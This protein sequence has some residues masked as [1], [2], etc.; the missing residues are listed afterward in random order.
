M[1]AVHQR[2]RHLRPRR[3][4][5]S[6]RR[7]SC[8]RATRPAHALRPRR[9]EFVLDGAIG[10]LELD[11]TADHQD[12]RYF[13]IRG[14]EVD[15]ARRR[16]ISGC[17]F[18]G[19][20]NAFGNYFTKRGNV[21]HVTIE[22]VWVHGAP[23]VPGGTCAAIGL[24]SKQGGVRE[25]TT[26]NV[27]HI[28]IDDVRIDGGD[29]GILVMTELSVAGVPPSDQWPADVNQVCDDIL[30]SNV[31]FD[32]GKAPPF[33]TRRHHVGI[34]VNG[35][36]RGGT[37]TVRDCSLKGSAD[38]L[39][40]IDN[41]RVAKV[42]GVH[43]EG[44][45]TSPSRC[46][47]SATRSTRSRPP[48]APCRSPTR[49]A[50]TRSGTRGAE[51]PTGFGYAWREI[52]RADHPPTAS[53]TS[54]PRH[55]AGWNLAAVHRT[56]PCAGV[57][58]RPPCYP[59]LPE[60]GGRPAGEGDRAERDGRPSQQPR[61]ARAGHEA[62]LD[63]DLSDHAE[64]LT[65]ASVSGRRL[66]RRLDLRRRGPAVRRLDRPRAPPHA[67]GLRHRH[68]GGRKSS[69]ASPTC[70]RSWGSAPR[71]CGAR[72]SRRTTWRPPGRCR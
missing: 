3:P 11:D 69:S 18:I 22:D 2:H 15:A 19:A 59:P 60:R 23:A 21:E 8:R 62:E 66:A 9:E 57:T 56:V 70:W 29:S 65:A 43:A 44:P 20:T 27:R 1:P 12:F 25:A 61:R 40:E 6:R 46:A 24:G 16:N 36:G 32:S 64:D 7:S 38:G 53:P 34:Q 71:W 58:S 30:I 68:A 54:L 26:N 49:T 48:R 14:F 72:R 13:A 28:T 33:R 37:L 47:A 51:A 52:N 55:P 45:S 35:W 39:L 41:M 5:G 4:T 17:A 50:P 67:G 63:D 31:H 10:F 42:T